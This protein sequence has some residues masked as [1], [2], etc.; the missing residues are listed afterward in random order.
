MSD[1]GA[2]SRV[3]G[4]RIALFVGYYDSPCVAAL[5][6][7]QNFKQ[8]IESFL[9]AMLKGSDFFPE[10]VDH[11]IAPGRLLLTTRS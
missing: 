11:G 8:L 6:H 3:A 7:A 2:I 4:R 1:L 9:H 10:C 5:G